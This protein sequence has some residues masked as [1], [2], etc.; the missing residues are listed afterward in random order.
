MLSHSDGAARVCEVFQRHIR[1]VFPYV[2]MYVCVWLTLLCCCLAVV[3]HFCG[4]SRARTGCNCLSPWTSSVNKPSERRTTPETTQLCQ[5]AHTHIYMYCHTLS[6]NSWQ[7]CVAASSRAIGAIKSCPD[8]SNGKYAMS[9]PATRRW[10]PRATDRCY[11]RGGTRWRGQ[12]QTQIQLLNDKYKY[13]N[14]ATQTQT[15]TQT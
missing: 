12:A 11:P 2:C 5:A 6:G 14:T 8:N 3:R 10:A 9:G 7:A 1:H 13:K 4:S 15:E